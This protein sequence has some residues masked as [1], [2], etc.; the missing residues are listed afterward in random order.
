MDEITNQSAYPLP[1]MEYIDKYVGNP[2]D[3]PQPPNIPDTTFDMFGQQIIPLENNSD[4]IPSLQSQGIVQIFKTIDETEK[5]KD[6]Q[7]NNSNQSASQNAISDMQ[8][9]NISLLTKF[10]D[11]VEILTKNPESPQVD[12]LQ[13]QLRNLF[14]N[15]HYLVNLYRPHQARETIISL[16]KS[17]KE[18]RGRTT[19]QLA[20]MISVIRN[21]R[22]A[23]LQKVKDIEIDELE[24]KN[25]IRLDQLEEK[26][27]NLDREFDMNPMSYDS[28]LQDD[29]MQEYLLEPLENF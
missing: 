7:E 27:E 8:S 5:Q 18:T 21:F 23:S 4:L 25:E 15:L 11:L 6:A 1:P 16:L 24:I 28:T 3:F 17:Q 14:E 9:I 2:A 22:D 20:K 12:V 10:L 29:L 13:Y 26:I 19:E